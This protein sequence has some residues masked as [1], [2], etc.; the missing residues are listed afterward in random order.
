MSRTMSR[1]KRLRRKF[2]KINEI[3][4]VPNLL[5]IQKRSY[6]S[7]LRSDDGG[8]EP[9]DVCLRATF[10]SVF[11]IESPDGSV[12]LNFLNYEIGEPRFDAEECRM[13]DLSFGAPLVVEFE[14][15]TFD[16]DSDANIRTFRLS[17][18]QKLH[19]GDVPMMTENG[20][21]VVNGAERVVVSQMHRS[22]GVFFDHDKG[23]KSAS[24][25]LRYSAR[26]IPYRGSWLEFEFDSRDKINFKVD[27]DVKLPVTMLL[28]AYG[29]DREGICRSL[30]PTRSFV[31]S[32]NGSG[33]TADVD[34]NELAGGQS[35]RD[36]IDAATGEV[37]LKKGQRVSRRVF[38]RL[39]DAGFRKELVDADYLLGKR[40]AREVIDPD[41]GVVFAEAGAPIS[42][43]LLESG[44]GE[45]VETLEPPDSGGFVLRMIESEIEEEDRYR[46]DRSDNCDYAQFHIYRQARSSEPPSL[47]TAQYFFEGLF[48]DPSRYDL[49]AVG[50][51]KLNQRL[52]LAV[53]DGARAL[54]AKRRARTLQAEDVIAVVR[55]LE[56]LRLGERPVDDIDHLGNRRV[57]S[58]GE[59][60]DQ[61]YRVGLMRMER[62]ARERV[63]RINPSDLETLKPEDLVNARS[64]VSVVR[65]FLAGSQLSQFM[66]QTNPLSEMAHKRR[67]SALGPRGLKRRNASFEVRDVHR[68]HYGRICPIET[69]EGANIGLVNS[70]ATFARVNR[71]GFIETPF[72]KVRSGKVTNNVVYL[73]AIEEKGWRIAQS[74]EPLGRGNRLEQ[75]EVLTRE[76][77]G[78]SE[79]FKLVSRNRVDLID[80]S[81]KQV[82]SVSASLIPFLENDDA[83][84]ALMG[85]N[86]QRQA[87]P[88]IEAEAPFVG[89]GMEGIVA[90]DSGA[91]IAARRSG[92]IDQVDASRI[93]VRVTESL[94]PG[95]PGVDI[96]RLRKFQRSN[97]NT[98]INQR[99]LVKIGDRVAAG[100]VIADGPSTDLGE[101]ALGRNVLVAFMPW[102]GYNFEDSILVS[103]RIVR[104]DVFTSIN[105]EEY[106]VVVRDT[107]LGPE[108][109]TRDLPNV[110][111]DALRNLDEAGVVY[112]GAQVSAG[113]ILVGKITPKGE[114]PMT[115]EEKLLRAIFG[116]KA[117]DV[118]DT[119]LRLPP[120][121]AG[122]V[123]EVRVFTRHGVDKDERA[124][125]IEAEEIERLDR[126]RKDEAAILERNVSAHLR[127][128]LK[129]RV[130][131]QPF[132]ELEAGAELSAQALKRTGCEALFRVAVADPEA[133]EGLAGFK[134]RYEEDLA[135]LERRFLDKCEKVRS[136]DDLQSG[137]IKIV[138]VFVAVKRK[139]QA[140]DKMAGRHGNKGVISRVLP[141]EDM[142]YLADGTPVDVVLNPLGVP[143]RMNVGQVLETHLGWAAH[144]WG[145]SFAML[146]T[147]SAG[148]RTAK[149]CAARWRRSTVAR[150]SRGRP[151]P[152]GRSS[153][154]RSAPAAACISR[155]RCSTVPARTTLP[156][157]CRR[158]ASKRAARRRS[159]TA[160]PANRSRER[161]PSA[162]STSLSCT[163]SWTTRSTPGPRDPTVW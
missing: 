11:P 79:I 48:S 158:R 87:V 154:S 112:I 106:E 13:R 86:M 46:A 66:D 111:E 17:K 1:Q 88:L 2:G 68:T 57:R 143:S 71:H 64:V 69:P 6:E 73:S 45:V 131:T 33:W 32:E 146:S 80:V 125:Q 94:D 30:Y 67:I 153:I 151:S 156:S 107:K 99:P 110:S 117:A 60:I 118:R 157:S 148:A 124:R 103:E 121:D 14:L 8:P 140:G 56:A 59:L 38:R 9:P 160:A 147:A 31:R 51:A 108:E 141:E 90:R 42:R 62:A 35:D 144:G 128:L 12:K 127:G 81:P 133:M 29:L 115:P 10:D 161:S 102:Q 126:D 84:R 97:Q 134:K 152:T 15:Q 114:I 3:A 142:P 91:V 104:E 155:P 83:N 109:V 92:T 150:R 72:R 5:E 116:E 61:Q 65:E 136:G 78:E 120:G 163:T 98:A 96:Y 113:D 50:R 4:E 139:L 119:S 149:D 93:V 135:G 82:V 52:G 16:V 137:L 44:I 34:I 25:K 95:D 132:G 75:D 138:K 162:T 37:I 54:E 55:E 19:L 130:L 63:K 100:D 36:L 49:S 159:M 39:R 70:F 74:N 85:S 47:A 22:P 18:V 58:V 26:V 129:D 21:F 76:D 23:K 7:F 53:G 24:G 145:R 43:K 27:R 77:D 41:T 20:T 122:T 40:S 28:Y 105:I 101:L 123:V 89:T